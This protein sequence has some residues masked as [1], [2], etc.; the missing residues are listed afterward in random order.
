MGIETLG[1]D[2]ARLDRVTARIEADIAA[3]SSDGCALIVSRRG[4]IVYREVRGFA[5]REAARALSENDTFATMSVGKQFTN[6]LVLSKIDSGS[7][8]L[9][10]HVGDI[11]PEFKARG[12]RTIT[13]FH[14]LTHTSGIESEWPSVSL[15]VLL[16][17]GAL[18]AHAAGRRPEARPG[19]AVAYSAVV[20]HSILAEMVRRADGGS[21][22]YTQIMTEDLFRPLGMNDTALGP[23]ADLLDRLCPVKPKFT[24]DMIPAEAIYSMN[25]ILRMEGELPAGGYVTTIGDLHRFT[26]MLRN[27]GTIDGFRLLSPRLIEYCAQNFTGDLTNSLWDYTRDMK[28]W[29]P[30]P[31]SMGI[32]FWVRGRGI[33]PG[34]LSNLSSPNTF[35]GWG[36][37]SAAFWIDPELDLTFAFLSAGLMSAADHI[38]RIQRLSDLVIGAVVEL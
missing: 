18:T 5:D 11:I 36:A 22:S 15:D 27:K 33:Q 32:G 38:E 23:R 34:P 8:H 12:L 24:E 9:H 17:I 13:L 10:M 21:R 35:G 28:G 1:C 29:E 31:A 20:A 25:A 37:G 14:L 26:M 2:K 19:E 30:W 6:A 7:L 16:D 4:E 3:G